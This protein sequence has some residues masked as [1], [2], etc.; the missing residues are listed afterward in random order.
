MFSPS[1]VCMYCP[2]LWFCLVWDMLDIF[3]MSAIFDWPPYWFGAI[4]NVGHIRFM[5]SKLYLI[6]LS[7]L[8]VKV[9]SW[10]LYLIRL[11]HYFVW[12][13]TGIRKRLIHVV[14]FYVVSNLCG[15]IVILFVITAELWASYQQNVERALMIFWLKPPCLFQMPDRCFLWICVA[16]H[17]VV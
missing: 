9:L 5:V 6:Y 12:S 17:P 10:I 3:V 8:C 15:V 13:A 16:R 1:Y 7:L 14:C 4:L 2:M 11:P